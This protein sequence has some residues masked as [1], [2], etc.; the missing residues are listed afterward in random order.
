MTKKISHDPQLATNHANK[1]LWRKYQVMNGK[2]DDSAYHEPPCCDVVISS[3][4]PTRRVTQPKILDSPA[5]CRRLW[6]DFGC[7]TLL[8]CCSGLATGK[9]YSQSIGG[10]LL[11][12]NYR[13]LQ[14][15]VLDHPREKGVSE[16]CWTRLQ[17]CSGQSSGKRS[18]SLLGMLLNGDLIIPTTTKDY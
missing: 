9:C 10:V 3:Q 2:T 15:K 5:E 7:W 12:A 13:V 11:N 14:P 17:C 1:S 6:C 16:G 8:K 4:W 18:T